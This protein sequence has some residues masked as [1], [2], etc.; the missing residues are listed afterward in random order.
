MY[1][2]E[3]PVKINYDDNEKYKLA[4]DKYFFA[5]YG[6]KEWITKTCDERVEIVAKLIT[7]V[8]GLGHS[9]SPVPVCNYY[10]DD[11]P[12]NTYRR[13]EKGGIK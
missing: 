3:I 8:A 12:C 11:V 9:P 7:S 6:F 4:V 2:M 1:I 10:E 5:E 13:Y